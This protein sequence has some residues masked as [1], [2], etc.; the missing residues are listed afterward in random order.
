MK[1]KVILFVIFTV[2]S[3]NLF[4]Q[5]DEELIKNVIQKSYIDAIMNQGV[6]EH[7]T[8]G[9]HPCFTLIG[10][11]KDQTTVSLLPIYNWIEYTR[12]LKERNPE[13]SKDKYICEFKF[14]DITGNTA[15]AKLELSVNSNKV[16]TDYVGLYKFKDG[17]KIVNKIYQSAE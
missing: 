10:L 16:F 13:G 17:W 9:F 2:I 6:L 11:N 5:N 7:A 12:Q 15:M 4:S 1:T 14:I 8:D 3:L